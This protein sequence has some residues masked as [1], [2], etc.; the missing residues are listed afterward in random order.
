MPRSQGELLPAVIHVDP[1]AI[2][3]VIDGSWHRSRLL[4]IPEPGQPLVMLCG[5]E[6]VAAFEPLANRTA[7]GVSRQC[8]NCDRIYRRERGMTPNPV[9]RR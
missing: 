6:G 5:V 4:G 7:N 1:A 2:H 8:P 9:G 3:P